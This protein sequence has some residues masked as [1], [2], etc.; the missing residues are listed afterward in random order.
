[1]SFFVLLLS[2]CFTDLFF[3]YSLLLPLLIVLMLLLPHLLLLL[4]LLLLLAP[5]LLHLLLLLP[6]LLLLIEAS[7]PPTAH[8]KF[9]QVHPNLSFFFS[10]FSFLTYSDNRSIKVNEIWDKRSMSELEAVG[11]E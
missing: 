6:L 9:S 4:I 8:R 1:M 11:C 3:Y 10:F 7:A 5:L 2:I